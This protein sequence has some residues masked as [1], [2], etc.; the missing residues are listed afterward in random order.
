MDNNQPKGKRD[1]NKPLNLPPSGLSRISPF[2]KKGQSAIL[3]DNKF[4]KTSVKGT[5]PQFRINQHKGA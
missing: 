3:K 2:D 4:S 1:E 5:A